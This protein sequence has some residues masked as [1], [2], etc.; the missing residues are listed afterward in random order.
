MRE[1]KSGDSLEEHCRFSR[2]G[3]TL[4]AVAT[5]GQSEF[6]FLQ[7]PEASKL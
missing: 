4:V 7:F 1:Y 3:R 6:P 5:V 2:I